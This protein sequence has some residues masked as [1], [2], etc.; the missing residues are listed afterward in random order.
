MKLN[1]ALPPD[2]YKPNR[3]PKC[4][5]MFR[6]IRRSRSSLVK[7]FTYYFCE[8]CGSVTYTGRVMIEAKKRHRKWKNG[9]RRYWGRS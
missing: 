2:F 8:N 1:Q 6:T 3:C 5:V 9:L 4:R 7:N